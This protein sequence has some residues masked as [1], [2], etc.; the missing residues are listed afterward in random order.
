MREFVRDYADRHELKV[1]GNKAVMK[2]DPP[3]AGLVLGK[4][5]NGVEVLK[6]ED[7]VSRIQVSQAFNGYFPLQTFKCIIPKAKMSP[8]YSLEFPGLPP[9]THKGKLDS[10]E[11]S[12]G[13]RSGN[14]K[15][16]LVHNLEVFGIDPAQFAHK[17]QVS[18]R[19]DKEDRHII[20]HLF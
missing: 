5:E 10:V 11:L 12:V 18:E 15:V 17:C 16:T 8:G 6:W 4:G 20:C 9:S 19:K 2:L 1:E 14:K 7:V 3:M 13:Q